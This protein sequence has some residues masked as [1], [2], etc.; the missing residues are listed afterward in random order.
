MDVGI[1]GD[2]RGNVVYVAGGSTTGDIAGTIVQGDVVVIQ[3]PAQL[4][5]LLQ[6]APTAAP[7]ATPVSGLEAPAVDVQ[8]YSDI[9]ATAL[10]GLRAAEAGGQTIDAVQA[11]EVRVS[12]AELLLKRAAVLKAEAAQMMN[13]NATKKQ[14]ALQALQLRYQATNPFD[15]GAVAQLQAEE[16]ALVWRDFDRQAFTS[17]LSEARDLLDEALSVDET[18]TEALLQLAELLMALTPDDVSDEERVLTRAHALLGH[19]STDD[20][21]FKQAQALLLSAQSLVLKHQRTPPGPELLGAVQTCMATLTEARDQFRRLER[22]LWATMADQMLQ[23]LQGALATL[24]AASSGP[25]SPPPP[26]A[27]GG[28]AAAASGPGYSFQPAGQWTVSVSMGGVPTEQAYL[29]MG[30]DQSMQGVVSPAGMTI[31]GRWDFM[32]VTATLVLQG[33]ANGMIP[34]GLQLQIVQASPAA[35]VGMDG[36]GATYQFVRTG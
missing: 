13:E 3:M 33:V 31:Q 20:E 25:S 35:A 2:N 24:G 4:R 29:A 6:Q 1:E 22:M 36:R 18:N 34:Y 7:P 10:A 5:T 32:P 28:N 17:K 30:Y 15:A 27:L 23:R 26:F 14:P 19:A 21:R 8:P 12:K 16:E 11:G 9:V